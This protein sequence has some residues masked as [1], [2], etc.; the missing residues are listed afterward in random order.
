MEQTNL[1]RLYKALK[2]DGYDMPGLSQFRADM[3]DETKLRN[4]YNNLSSEYELPEWGE[5]RSDMGIAERVWS[6]QGVSTMDDAPL[7]IAGVKGKGATEA[8]MQETRTLEQQAK[9]GEYQ[10]P[11]A[12][13]AHKVYHT[14]PNNPDNILRADTITRTKRGNAA[15][16]E[17]EKPEVM[18]SSGGNT[19]QADG[20]FRLRPQRRWPVAVWL[21]SRCSRAST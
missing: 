4:L 15:I 17:V 13:E 14:D 11:K 21:A 10:A 12:G 1:D 7:D 2:A 5:F 16:V 18:G 20:P 8:Q 19:W 3:A 9:A 6:P